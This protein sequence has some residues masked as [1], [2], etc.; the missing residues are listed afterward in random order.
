MHFGAGAIQ[1]SGNPLEERSIYKGYKCLLQYLFSGFLSFCGVAIILGPGSLAFF[2]SG[3]LV[4]KLV[5]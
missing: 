2:R 4:Q 1:R 5:Q 3:I